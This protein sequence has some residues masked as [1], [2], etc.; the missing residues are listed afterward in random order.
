[1]T[2]LDRFSL[3]LG[4]REVLHDV[5]LRPER[6]TLMVLCGPNGAGKTSTLR[7]FAGLVPGA[8]ATNPR[9]VAYLPQNAQAT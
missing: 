3:T 1:M 4:G 6:G 2:A 9:H 5:T 7:A 8:P